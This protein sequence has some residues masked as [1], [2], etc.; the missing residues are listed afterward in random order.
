MGNSLTTVPWIFTSFPSETFKKEV[1]NALLEYVQGSK[2]WDD[3]KNT[4]TEKWKSER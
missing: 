2:K 1:G 4:V 3:V